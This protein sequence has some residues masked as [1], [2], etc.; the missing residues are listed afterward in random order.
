MASSDYQ[1]V[2]IRLQ[3]GMII[4]FTD[5]LGRVWFGYAKSQLVVLDGNRVRRFGPSDNLQVGNITAIHGRGPE[6]WI[7]SEFGLE[8]F[9]QGRFHKIAAVDDKW[10]IA[11]MFITESIFPS[12]HSPGTGRIEAIKRID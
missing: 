2:G 6:I 5:S 12:R 8:Q 10:H 7:G 11:R 1:H 4:A 9:D 3:R